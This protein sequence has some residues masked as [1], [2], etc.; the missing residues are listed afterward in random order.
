MLALKRRRD[1]QSEDDD[2]EPPARRAFAPA[3][4]RAADTGEHGASHKASGCRDVSHYSFT[5]VIDEGQFGVVYEARD[6]VSGERVAIKQ[7][8]LFNE[9]EGYPVSSLREIQALLRC[10]HP[11]IVHMREMLTDGAGAVFI[12]MEHGGVS[13][14]QI[15]EDQP[16]YFT[17]ARQKD[18]LRQLLGAV[19]Y[20]HRA[21]IMHRD[22]KTANV[23]LC[24]RT[25]AVKVADFGLAREYGEPFV[26]VYFVCAGE[27]TRACECGRLELGRLVFA[28]YACNMLTLG[29]CSDI[30]GCL[31]VHAESLAQCWRVQSACC[32]AVVPRPRVA[33]SPVAL[34]AGD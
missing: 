4:T 31:G 26:C 1:A 12:V 20:M 25:G 23:L 11:N 14:Q 34:W 9:S 22:L 13:V 30:G 10:R 21:W 5:S 29:S 3:D 17:H 15:L 24:C 33:S 6:A 18:L 8:K 7:V 27:G 2:D 28:T 32:H 16:D 19:A